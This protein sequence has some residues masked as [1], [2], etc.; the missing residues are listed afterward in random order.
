MLLSQSGD[1]RTGGV[2]VK[3]EA[4]ILMMA[5]SRELAVT[6]GESAEGGRTLAAPRPQQTAQRQRTHLSRVNTLWHSQDT[7]F[8]HFYP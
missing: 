8:P 2:K 1:A 6:K 7:P 5:E 3:A 4:S